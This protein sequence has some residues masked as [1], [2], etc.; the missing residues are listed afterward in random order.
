MNTFMFRTLFLFPVLTNPV[1]EKVQHSSSW[2]G[3]SGIDSYESSWQWVWILVRCYYGYVLWGCLSMRPVF[4]LWIR[5]KNS[6]PLKCLVWLIRWGEAQWIGKAD[7]LWIEET[8]WQSFW[9]SMVGQSAKWSIGSF[10]SPACYLKI[11]E[12][13][14]FHNSYSLSVSPPSFSLLLRNY[15]A[16]ILWNVLIMPK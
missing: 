14:S 11:L 12:F 7:W 10:G 8:F 1:A 4:E 3:F 5:V 2:I 9:P 16:S 6:C 15:I 13:L